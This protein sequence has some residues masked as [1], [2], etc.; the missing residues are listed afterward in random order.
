MTKTL[1]GTH[2]NGS[3]V[4]AYT[5]ENGEL[6]VRFLPLG[7]AIDELWVPNS[8]GKLSNVLVGHADLADR[9]TNNFA[10]GE[11]CGRVCNRISGAKFSLNGEEFNLTPSDEGQYTLHG[12]KE[13][14][15][16]LWHV[17]HVDDNSIVFTYTSP[18]G[19]HGF[20]GT[21]QTKVR[22]T[23]EA[24]TVLIEYEAVS[25]ADTVI[26]VTNHA[27]F[28]LA[29]TG[30]G[31]IFNQ[32]LC[33]DAEHYLPLNDELCPTGE[34]ASVAGTQ[35]D[36]R[37]FREIGQA[38]DVNFCNPRAIEAIDPESGRRMMVET[39]LPGVQLYTGDCLPEPFSGFCLETQYWPDAP[40]QPDFPSIVVRA[41]E[42]WRS[43][44]KFS[45]DTVS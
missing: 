35:F 22:Y 29:G 25:D 42:V 16:A 6:K 17:A 37:Q 8:H 7:A 21:V 40:N 44:T 36:F 14:N 5:L 27:Y 28:N 24:S 20:P 11:I 30:S 23:L 43:W 12:A 13:F 45:F 1:Y 31:Q 33:I 26:N 32:L 9:I 38:Y 4:Y 19:T 15:T 39:D 3:E 34:V 18:A 10:Q 41:G 2:P